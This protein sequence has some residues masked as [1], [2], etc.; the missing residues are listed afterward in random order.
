MAQNIASLRRED[1]NDAQHPCETF[2]D[3][4]LR[5]DRYRRPSPYRLINYLADVEGDGFAELSAKILGA[6]T[7]TPRSKNR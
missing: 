6:E 2:R 1:G 3:R 7:I 4:P 5:R